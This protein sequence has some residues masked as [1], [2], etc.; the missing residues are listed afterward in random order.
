MIKSQSAW[1]RLGTSLAVLLL[2]QIVASRALGEA[3]Q[4]PSLASYG[5]S[6]DSYQRAANYSRQ[7]AGDALVVM[8]HGRIVFEDYAEGAGPDKPHRL[9]SGTKTFWGVLAV[10]AAQDGLLSLDEKVS[11][12]LTEWQSDPHK[13]GITVR[14][15]LNFTSGLDPA[16]K[17]FKG[18]P[19]STDKFKDVIQIRSVNAPGRTFDYGPSH[20]VGFGAF[21]QRKLAAAGKSSD[22]LEY[23]QG[24]ILAPIGLKV[25]RW[26]TDAV[27]N[28][29][30]PAGAYIAPREWIKLG[31]LL[32]NQGSWNG[33]Q[34]IAPAFL[35]QMFNGSEVSPYY[36]LTLWLNKSTRGGEGIEAVDGRNAR[37]R[38]KS[39]DGFIYKDGPTDLAMAAGQGIQ[40]LYIIP[41]LD[42]VILRQG[43]SKGDWVDK[44][45]LWILLATASSETSAAAHPTTQAGSTPDWL[46]ACTADIR[47]L[48]PA[49]SEGDNKVLRRCLRQHRQEVSSEC[50]RAARAARKN[51]GG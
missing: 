18:N 11:D 42:M 41:S 33:H 9:A 5:P 44:E 35:Q 15:L 14:Q 24:R 36:G 46:S 27:G 47:R 25:G 37:R 17:L 34:V 49:D 31:Q 6:A 22:P 43:D 50:R 48:C 19:K 13:E 7:H 16:E 51:S 12:T 26:T 20:L 3:R 29:I 28:P 39:D 10:A 2:C 32:N 40:R 21:L 45:F 38:Q 8:S 23:L 4:T 1:Q 30:M